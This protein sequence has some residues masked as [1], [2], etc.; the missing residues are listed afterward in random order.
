M[1]DDDTT[2]SE[3]PMLSLKPYPEYTTCGICSGELWSW[4]GRV[5]LLYSWDYPDGRWKKKV[6][7]LEEGLK[8]WHKAHNA[9]HGI[10][11]I[12]VHE[13]CYEFV[14]DIGAPGEGPGFVGRAVSALRFGVDCSKIDI[15]DP[16]GFSPAVLDA[17]RRRLNLSGLMRLPMEVLAMVQQYSNEAPL[18]C[19][20]RAV[21]LRMELLSMP[22]GTE[23]ISTRPFD[24]ESWT[25]GDKAPRL[26]GKSKCEKANS[27]IRITIDHHGIC[28]VEALD[29]H[30]KP[31]S[32]KRSRG[33]KFVI[34]CQDRMRD[35]NIDMYFKDGLSWLRDR[36]GA[37]FVVWD[38]PTPPKSVKYDDDDYSEPGLWKLESCATFPIHVNYQLYPSIIDLRAGCTGLT[39]YYE[40]YSGFPSDIHAHAPASPGHPRDDMF[41]IYVPLPPGEEILSMSLLNDDG[42][43]AYSFILKTKLAGLI[44][45][46]PQLEFSVEVHS[47]SPKALIYTKDEPLPTIFAIYPESQG[48]LHHLFGQLDWKSERQAM[49]W[50]WAPLKGIIR[51]DVYQG[52]SSHR[53]AHDALH[54]M[55]IW[56]ENGAQRT[57]GECRMSGSGPL[58]TWMKPSTLYWSQPDDTPY[59]RV[60]FDEDPKESDPKG[61]WKRDDLIGDVHFWMDEEQQYFE[62]VSPEGWGRTTL[63]R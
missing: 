3:I 4:L 41:A 32:D 5:V 57:V 19:F 58:K 25:R 63:W 23:M 10:P 36:T 11:D 47:K 24:V 29:D 42:D 28:R 26:K 61:E 56:Y 46:G 37:R 52:W 17:A 22:R 53:D 59:V 16:W 35:G 40:R 2:L 62:V 1:E 12:T 31:L 27:V 43:D 45:V 49:L 6:F 44:H 21:A 18:W 30:P 8:A 20:A 14:S 50:S 54:G 33:K 39:F 60:Q 34:L 7:E 51:V 55:H 38:T 15:P 48:T 9:N 13:H